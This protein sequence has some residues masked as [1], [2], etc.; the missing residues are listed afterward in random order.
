MDEVT[1]TDEK[2]GA[3]NGIIDLTFEAALRQLEE[4]VASLEAG[5]L[6]LEEALDLYETGQRLTQY[7]SLILES[8]DLK[9]E[10]LT[11]DG[12]I[13]EVALE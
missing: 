11:P 9:L 12:E 5:N 2:L 1:E 8:A 3:N 13:V 7:C 4:T 10:Q 6:T